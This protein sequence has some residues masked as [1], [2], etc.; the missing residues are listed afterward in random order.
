MTAQSAAERRNALENQ[1]PVWP[2]HT[3]SAHFADQ[4]RRYRERPFLITET[5]T[6]SYEDIWREGRRHAKALL[7]LGV[8]RREHVAVLMANEPEYAFLMLGVW[9]A[10]AV[11]VPINTM[12]RGEEISYLINQS[13]SR[14][15][16]LHQSAGGVPHSAAIA[17]QF[18]TLVHTEDRSGLKR[19]VCIQNTDTPLD[20]RFLAWASFME[21]GDGVS[22]EQV[23]A[24]MAQSSYPDEVADIIYTS[25]STGA[26]KGVMI[27]HD[28]FL[29]AAFI[30]ALSRAFEDGRRV[31]TALPLYHVFALVVG[32]LAVSFVG[33]AL[34]I[35]PS[36]SPRL[37]LQMVEKH[38]ANDILCVPSMLVALLNHPDLHMF[39]TSSLYAMLC[40]A[41]PAPIVV[42]QRAIELLELTEVCTAY[43]GTEA[44]AGTVYTDVGDPIATVA[45]RVGRIMPG[46]SSGLPEFGGVNVQYKTV[47]PFTGEDLP[48]G[49]V[50][51]LTV[52][53]NLVTRGYFNKPDETAAVIDKDGWLRSGDLGRVDDEGYIEFLGRS[54]DLY[55]ISGENVAPKEVEEAISR[56]PAVAQV[57]VVGV[58]DAMTTE[59]G[60]AFVELRPNQACTRREIVAYCREHLARFKAPRYV[61]F[62]TAADWPLTGTGKIQKFRLKEMAEERI[63]VQDGLE[64]ENY[65]ALGT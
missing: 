11:C 56:H 53:G 47:D 18:E 37:S 15:L 4:A 51:E 20:P 26:P 58:R 23:D 30:N 55:K 45:S 16:F 9:L 48:Q 65:G 6:Y 42:W 41:A 46:G 24:R 43:G 64:K 7:G 8:R 33:G 31:Y 1:Y 27:T 5:A 57:Y 35:A 13:E 63:R 19:V 52:R 38:K 3:L 61:W 29:R 17:A 39:D 49:S 25:G 32:L 10:G 34:I 28:M 50:G 36:F 44:T 54:K 59:T 60:A 2:R 22:E 40:A 62:V 21:M 14:W 12:L